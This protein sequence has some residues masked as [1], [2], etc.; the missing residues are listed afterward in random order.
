MRPLRTHGRND[1]RLSVVSGVCSEAHGL[2]NRGLRAVRP[3]NEPRSQ[4]T[5]TGLDT[6]RVR[7]YLKRYELGGLDDP[8]GGGKRVEQRRFRE[9]PHFLGVHQLRHLVPPEALAGG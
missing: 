3:H 4:F 2:P 7:T 1:R 5:G 9:G 8:T 6:H